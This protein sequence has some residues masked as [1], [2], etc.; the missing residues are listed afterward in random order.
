[1]NEAEVP[2]GVLPHRAAASSPGVMVKHD[3]DGCYSDPSAKL[4]QALRE[5]LRRTV[6]RLLIS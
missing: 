1:M 5:E 2:S 6:D 4:S 3:A